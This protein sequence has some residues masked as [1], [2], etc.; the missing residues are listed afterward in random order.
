MADECGALSASDMAYISGAIAPVSF[1]D[2]CSIDRLTLL[3]DGFGGSQYNHDVRD[4]IPVRL[5]TRV[6]Q[7]VSDTI[8]GSAGDQRQTWEL[9]FPLDTDIRQADRVTLTSGLTLEVD[10]LLTPMSYQFELR[11]VATG[12]TD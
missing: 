6:G 4:D 11:A 3:P 12:V 2:T 7:E 9:A 1:P 8:G 10:S 5:S